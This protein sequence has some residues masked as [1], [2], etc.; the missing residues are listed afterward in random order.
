MSLLGTKN[1]LE[2]KDSEEKVSHVK[3]LDFVMTYV[4]IFQ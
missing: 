2:T 4:E 1:Q 3:K